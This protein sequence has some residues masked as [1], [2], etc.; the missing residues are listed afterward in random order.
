MN[1]TARVNGL[2]QWLT[3]VENFSAN[4]SAQAERIVG[5]VALEAKKM[6]LAEAKQDAPNNLHNYQRGR[7]ARIGITYPKPRLRK[8]G[9]WW[10]YLR[11]GPPGP[12]V[13]LEDGAKDHFIPKR[14]YRKA[15]VLKLAGFTPSAVRG[16]IF[17]RGAPAKKTW[18]NGRQK[19]QA[20][21]SALFKKAERGALI[22]SLKG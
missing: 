12:F 5:E 8:T 11:P 17:V 4:A 3:R 2:D 19:V 14:K 21:K 16:Q 18:T 1:A 7:G 6:M 13:L 9:D 22:N 15:R 10:T 20:A